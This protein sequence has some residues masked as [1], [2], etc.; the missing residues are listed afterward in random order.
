MEVTKECAECHR[1][2]PEDD[3]P[4]CRGK[5]RSQCK[6]CCNKRSK[7]WRDKQKSQSK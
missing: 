6:D 5:P 1:D 4:I 7:K 3:F 2:L